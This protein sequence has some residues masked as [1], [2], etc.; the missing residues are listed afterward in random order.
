MRD[1]YDWSPTRCSLA[2]RQL[3]ESPGFTAVAVITLA[4]GIGANTGIFTLVNAVLL[5]SLPVPNPEQRYLVS[6]EAVTTSEIEGEILDRASLQ[7]S[8]G[9]QLG[10]ATDERRVRSAERGIG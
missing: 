5:K 6:T 9:R 2:L 7:S 1:D 4:L 10:L 3:R 8:L